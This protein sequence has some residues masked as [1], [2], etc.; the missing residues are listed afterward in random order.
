MESASA[1]EQDLPASIESALDLQ[2]ADWKSGRSQRVEDYLRQFPELEHDREGVLDLIYQDFILRRRAGENVEATEYLDRFPHRAQEILEQFAVSEAMRETC[3]PT[4]PLVEQSASTLVGPGSLAA[5][6]AI[7][8]Y[9]ILGLL[10]RGAMGVVYK[11]RELG[12]G[13]TVALKTLDATTSD[14]HNAIERLRAEAELIARLNHPNII[15]IHAV[16]EHHERPFLV[17]EYAER[18]NLEHS[19]AIGP[20]APLAAAQLVETLARALESAHQGGI[21]HRDLKPSNVLLAADGTPKIADFG[22]AKLLDQETAR[23]LSGELLGT[24]SYMSPEQA[25]GR[26]KHVGP[27]ADVYSLGAILYRA[28]TGRPPFEG[29]SPVE[30]LK[31]VLDSDPVPPRRQQPGTPRDL[32]T[33]VL[34][35]LEKDPRKRYASALALAQDLER[36]R[37]GLSI[38]ARPVGALGKV[39]RFSHRNPLLAAAAAMLLLTFSLGTP[40]LLGLWLRARGD[41]QRAL[42]ARDH[43]ERSRDRALGAVATLLGFEDSQTRSEEM[44]PY[45]KLMVEAG[46]R[47][48]IALVRELEQDPR[49]ADQL[50]KAYEMLAQIRYDMGDQSAAVESAQAAVA[51]AQR[52]VQGAPTSRV[53]RTR[54]ADTLHRLG[55]LD[56]KSDAG[57]AAAEGSNAIYRELQAEDPASDPSFFRVQLARN[58]YNTGHGQYQRGQPE[59]AAKSFREA[60]AILRESGRRPPTTDLLDLDARCALYLARVLDSPAPNDQSL[61]PARE[62]CAIYRRIVAE[63]P[64]E[65]AWTV[66]LRL[67]CEELGHRF[68]LRDRNADAALCYAE[69]RAVLLKFLDQSGV[70]VAQ[71]ASIQGQIAQVD[72]NL[73]VALDAD[74]A[75]N[76]ARRREV[77]TEAFRICDKLA[78]IVR[79]FPDE[80]TLVH[81]RVC[82][83]AARYQEVDGSQLDLGLLRESERLWGE[84]LAR[85]PANLEVKGYLAI[86]RR[87]LADACADRGLVDE[88]DHWRRL[89]PVSIGN[90]H[91]LWYEIAAEYAMTRKNLGCGDPANSTPAVV[92]VREDLAANATLALRMAVANGFN[93][94][95]QLA[96]DAQFEWLRPRADFQAILADLVV[97]VDPFAPAARAS[98]GTGK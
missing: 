5:A 87:R 50:A 45:R 54:L 17:L 82:L 75:H 81:A 76:H 34:K 47:E 39:V 27:A 80:L 23:T 24:P 9:Q 58:H 59:L 20:L 94:S 6:D 63:R 10:G 88:A 37:T 91:G 60:R 29:E 86:V 12:L 41:R 66:Q 73:R 38:A 15:Q 4:L 32:E 31:L 25:S 79:P 42:I 19:L 11:A 65:S 55:G 61:E 69:A 8:G 96:T 16:G 98:P 83:D 95:R 33:I 7:P 53:T 46:L 92:K 18:G 21:V 3:P 67:A 48:S 51:V 62:A 97:S 68:L 57:Q 93:A 36:F 77:S 84:L 49:A 78:L 35:C 43:A 52:E 26:S 70:S 71:R 30:T 44:R 13:R 14:R 74:P 90:D 40:A 64:D 2:Y 22:L 89:W 85:Q 72:H 56:P 28:I 1:S